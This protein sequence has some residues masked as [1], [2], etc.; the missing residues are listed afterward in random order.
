MNSAVE[1]SPTQ[2]SLSHR[3][4]SPHA[5]AKEILAEVLRYRHVA[6]SAACVGSAC[7]ACLS[8]HLVK[9]AAAISEGRPITL[10]LPA[11]PG[12]SPNAAKVLGPLPDLAERRALEFLDQLCAR[13][14]ARYAPGARV[15]LCSDGRV[16]SDVVG[17]EEA[18]VTAYQR[19][20]SRLIRDQA[21]TH[22]ETFNLEDIFPALSFHEMRERLMDKFGAAPEE[23]RRKVREGDAPFADRES[24]EALRMYRGITRFLVED[25]THPGQTKS[26]TAVQKDCRA[27]AYEVIRRSNAWSSLI[28]EQFPDA[29]RLSIH[30]QTCGAKKVGIR[31]LDS[32]SWM[33]PWHGV[34]LETGG[35]I[36]LIKRAQAE[37]MGARLVEVDGR[38]SH[39][40]LSAGT[41][42]MEVT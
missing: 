25:A 39:F 17:M 6:G 26:R 27:R 7:A 22:L 19:E 28:E 23:L 31:L 40:E 16:F 29:I 2:T 15:I 1:T 32:E 35:R 38:A 12:K 21:L 3:D 8:P 18:N 4:A 33:T 9:A 13:I 11:F 34:A 37:A 36:V 24:Q 14:A 41:I 30:P 42:P 20:I 10:V 5:L